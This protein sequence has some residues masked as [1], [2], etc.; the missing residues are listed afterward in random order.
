M[1]PTGMLM[2]EF[3]CLQ[4]ELDSKLLV[5]VPYFLIM[6]I[7]GSWSAGATVVIGSVSSNVWFLS[8]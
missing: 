7:I 1:P 6:L 4:P 5:I 3:L 8:A 2:H